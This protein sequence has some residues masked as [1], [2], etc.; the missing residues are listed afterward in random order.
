MATK[1]VTILPAAAAAAGCTATCESYASGTTEDSGYTTRW[2]NY[3][4]VATAAAGWSVAKIECKRQRTPPGGTPVPA[5]TMIGFASP[6]PLDS[7]RRFDAQTEPCDFT[8][9]D[10]YGGEDKTEI[11]GVAV[12]FI[13]AR[14][15]THLL[16]NSFNREPRVQLVY[17]PAT[18]LLVADY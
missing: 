16:V 12:T 10:P 2:T 18:N 7:D 6:L 1:P 17:D 5:P 11:T 9:S 14:T 13:F 15:P 3:Q 4:V 8:I